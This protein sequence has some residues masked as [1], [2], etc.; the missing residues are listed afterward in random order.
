[1][2]GPL[3]RSVGDVIS[4]KRREQDIGDVELAHDAD[5]LVDELRDIESGGPPTDEQLAA[6]SDSLGTDPEA[7]RFAAGEIPDD[8]HDALVSDPETALDALRD[9]LDTDD[10]GD[11]GLAAGINL[12][13]ERESGSLFNDDCRDVLPALADE[14]VDMIFADPPFNLDKDYGEDADDDIAEDEYLQWCTE[15]ID[16][17][18]RVLKPGGS[19]FLY[20]MPR[21]NVHLAD[22]I[23]RYLAL[24]HWIAI[25]I[26]YSLPRPGRLYPSH[27]S[28]LYFTKGNDPA[29]FDPDR[30]PIDTCRHC[31]GEQS[32]YGGYKSKMN[33]EGV[34]LTDVWDDIPPVRHDKYTDRDANQLSAKMLYRTISMAT[35]PGDT[36]L[37]PF[38]GAG[39]TYAVAEQMDRDW[40]GIELHDC[41]PIIERLANPERD[42]S[43]IEEFEQE[44][45]SLFTADA[46]DLRASYKDEFGFNFD[47]YDLSECA[48]DPA[49]KLVPGT[50]T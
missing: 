10:T 21:W 20:N 30:L 2:A 8:I 26:K 7:L 50:R 40:I 5:M 17:C 9:A 19:F 23:S 16:E 41:E 44:H 18:I 27:Y 1:M 37:D 42:A 47:D 32:D 35:E 15:W 13:H 14:S 6:L 48:F 29:T 24:R 46:L 12:V 45:N 4:R 28:L 39:T 43:Q 36:V 33:P 34:S 38:G 31:G 11:S 3:F 25:D 22:Y 49:E